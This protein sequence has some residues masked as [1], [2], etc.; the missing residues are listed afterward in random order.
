MYAKN[1]ALLV[2]AVSTLIA[3][4]TR[5]DPELA[6]PGPVSIPPPEVSIELPL[7]QKMP[8]D[9]LIA[10][11]CLLSTTKSCMELD[12]RPFEACLAGSKRCRE[13][14]EGGIT[15]IERTDAPAIDYPAP[16]SR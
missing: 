14:G 1:I 16:P 13:K 5:P 10:H 9:H 6:G 8:R 7:E 12:P 4:T 11:A 15:L 3:C 2:C